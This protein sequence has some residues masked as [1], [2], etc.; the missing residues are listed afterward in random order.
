MSEFLVKLGG[1]GL[2]LGVLTLIGCCLFAGYLVISWALATGQFVS[3]LALVP[4]LAFLF[5]F[6][7]AF[8]TLWELTFG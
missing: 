5:I 6:L 3:L 1:I 2:L 7:G 8:G 4:V